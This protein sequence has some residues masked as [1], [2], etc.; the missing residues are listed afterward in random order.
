MHS[1]PSAS[2]KGPPTT[3][4]LCAP[5]L[6][7][8]SRQSNRPVRFRNIP[9]RRTSANSLFD[10]FF[11]PNAFLLSFHN[12]K[13]E[14]VSQIT[15]RF[16]FPR[17]TTFLHSFHFAFNT[18]TTHPND[19]KSTIFKTLRKILT[20][21]EATG[22]PKHDVVRRWNLTFQEIL[23]SVLQ[24][25]APIA[26]TPAKT[27]GCRWPCNDNHLKSVSRLNNQWGFIKYSSKIHATLSSFTHC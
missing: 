10:L 12:L 19:A 7:L 18:N 5:L 9:W 2:L 16:S 17:R 8:L 21:F 1:M 22:H 27:R 23:V 15:W 20:K 11:N 13:V 25:M 26:C 24:K 4:V 3:S 6:L 14:V